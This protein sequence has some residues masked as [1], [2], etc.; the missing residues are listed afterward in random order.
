MVCPY[1]EPD[2][3]P[4]N[5]HSNTLNEVTNHMDEGSPNVDIPVLCVL[6][7]LPPP[8]EPISHR[9]LSFT[10]AVRIP[11]TEGSLGWTRVR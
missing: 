11:N 5:D 8:Q 6:P 1:R 2:D 3:I 4:S 7:L 9:S 10:V